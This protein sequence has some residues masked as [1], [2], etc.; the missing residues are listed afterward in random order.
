MLT[1][2]VIALLELPKLLTQAFRALVPMLES[3]PQI[4]TVWTAQR[5]DAI[6]HEILELEGA[7]DP[8]H[9]ARLGELRIRQRHARGLHEALLS[10]IAAPEKGPSS[11]D[12]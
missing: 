4:L 6:N 12:K 10:R 7:A 5:L 8:K 1:S 3:L 11:A 2:A 9:R